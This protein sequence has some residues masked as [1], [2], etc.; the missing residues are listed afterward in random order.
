MMPSSGS[1]QHAVEAIMFSNAWI[2]DS[3]IALSFGIS[4]PVEDTQPPE[5]REVG[6]DLIN[7]IES[8]I[9]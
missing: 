7:Y 3:A 9:I 5:V 4:V 1:I 6:I 2:N 8:T